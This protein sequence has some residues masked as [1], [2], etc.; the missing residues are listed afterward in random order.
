VG[1]E[2]IDVGDMKIIEKGGGKKGKK[3]GGGLQEVL[4]ERE[5]STAVL[6]LGKGRGTPRFRTAVLAKK[7]EN[8][9][10]LKSYCLVGPENDLPRNKGS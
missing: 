4:M 1:A 8:A 5:N 9:W 6:H 2:G 7:R 3:R 10:A